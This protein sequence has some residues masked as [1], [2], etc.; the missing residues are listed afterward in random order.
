MPDPVLYLPLAPLAGIVVDALAH[1]LLARMIAGGAHV[2]IQFLSFALGLS[3][4]AG[5]LACLLWSHPFSTPDRIGYLLL[6]FMVYACLGFGLFN[7][8][9]AN[10]SS[11]RVRM[12][13][14]YHAVD[15][16]PLTDAAMFARYPAEEILTARL[17]RLVT[18]GQIRLEGGRYFH[19]EGGVALIAGLFS[20]LRRLLL[21]K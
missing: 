19:C 11:L 15:P 5:L 16:E 13:K 17:E 2:R 9:N 14:E 4:V 1:A 21:R 3:A 20:C 6:Y 8:I 10:V 12:L 7:V 18:G